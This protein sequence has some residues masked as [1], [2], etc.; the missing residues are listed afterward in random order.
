MNTITLLNCFYR[1]DVITDM[2]ANLMNK[3]ERFAKWFVETIC[4]LPCHDSEVIAKT[5][6]GL[7]KGIGTPD[8]IIE[9][10]TETG[11]NMVIVIE[12]KLGALEGVEQTNR[13]A[14]D[15]GKE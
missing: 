5:R 13:Y 7:G 12:N 4:E 3:E 15:Q 14:S 9:R 11:T 2:I 6:V 8:L 10:K 1:E